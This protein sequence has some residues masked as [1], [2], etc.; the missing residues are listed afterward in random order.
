MAVLRPPV[1]LAVA[2]SAREVPTGGWAFEPKLDGWRAAGVAETGL[3]HSR[4]GTP[5]GE[6]FP[7]VAAAVRQLGADAIVDGELVALRAG[8]LDFAALQAGPARRAREGISVVLVVFDLLAAEGRDL[9][10]WPYQRRRV[11]LENLVGPPRP[12]LQLVE[13]T[14]SRDIAL[15]WMDPAWATAGVEGAM[16]KPLSSRYVPGVRS[17]WLK[18]RQRITT[19]AVV[20]GVVGAD[21]VVLGKPTPAGWRAVGLSQPAPPGLLGELAV[22]L[23]PDATRGRVRLP[24]VVA[25][26]PGGHEELTYLP[27]DPE[28]VVEVDA[29]TAVEFGRWRHRPRIVRLRPDLAPQ[30][31]RA[32]DLP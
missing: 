15:E 24:A 14:S 25:G 28:V 5:L 30:D 7:E 27:V 32:A 17:G 31:L 8:R 29:D 13:M 9:R 4:R 3:V 6:R 23:T 11:E 1:A 2:A 12:H 16:A 18:I 21:A 19:E 20:L 10:T 26:L 22:A